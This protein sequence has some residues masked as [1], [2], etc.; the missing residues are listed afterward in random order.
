M[1]YVFAFLVIEGGFAG[2]A[3]LNPGSRLVIGFVWLGVHMVLSLP[4]LVAIPGS[5]RARKWER[6]GCFQVASMRAASDMSS[7]FDE[8]RESR[9]NGHE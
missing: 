8:A 5:I 6:K 2:L 3:F 1:S 7:E 9:G 4:L